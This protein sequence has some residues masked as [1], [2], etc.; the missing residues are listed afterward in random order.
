MQFGTVSL[1]GA[2]RGGVATGFW[3]GA[4]VAVG[5]VGDVNAVAGDVAVAA[6]VE[7]V[8]AGSDVD[9]NTAAGDVVVAAAVGLVA[10]GNEG[11]V[12]AAVGDFTVGDVSAA[13]AEDSG[14]VERSGCKVAAEQYALQ[15]EF[16]AGQLGSW[17]GAL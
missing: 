3:C 13:A 17:C 12:N 10:A 4:A 7:L 16:N 6:A 1:L 2:V 15:L 8:A 5:L 11:G 14:N 9:V